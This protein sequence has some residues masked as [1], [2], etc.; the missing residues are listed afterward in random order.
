MD[1]K[2][3]VNSSCNKNLVVNNSHQVRA[4]KRLHLFSRKWFKFN[5]YLLNT[6]ETC[7]LLPHWS[8]CSQLTCMMYKCL[9]NRVIYRGVFYYVHYKRKC[10]ETIV[11]TYELHYHSFSLAC[12]QLQC[13]NNSTDLRK[14][15]LRGKHNKFKTNITNK[16]RNSILKQRY[17]RRNQKSTPAST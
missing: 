15:I 8:W 17:I 3:I 16:M 10:P 2:I 11:I 4:L 7:M 5:L 12:V 13:S 6:L 14:P 1:A 9:F